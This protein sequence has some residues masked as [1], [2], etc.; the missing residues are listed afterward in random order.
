ML[1][2][3]AL[4]ESSSPGIASYWQSLVPALVYRQAFRDVRTYALF[5]GNPHSG[6]ALVASLLNAHRHTLIAHDTNT[7]DLVQRRFTRSQLFW[8]LQ[9]RDSA[10][11]QAG[12]HSTGYDYCVR[13]Q[14]QSRNENL[15]VVG[16]HHPAT[17]RTLGE[18]T[19]LLRQ[20]RKTVRVPVK[21]V[22]VVRNPLDCIASLHRRERLPLAEAVEHYLENS[23]IN[24]WLAHTSPDGVHTMHLEDLVQRPATRLSELCGFLELDA[25]ADYLRACGKSMFAQPRMARHLVAWPPVLLHRLQNRC[26]TIPFLQCYCGDIERLSQANDQSF[27]VHA[28]AA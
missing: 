7:L 10:F 24:R 22:H 1:Y 3:S 2:Y 11:E 5:V 15:L 6:C 9:S 20:L 17:T 13:G 14:W 26:Q 21:I 23:A 8:L 16:G 19:D 12:R 18:R 4:G 28:Q 27:T 25:P